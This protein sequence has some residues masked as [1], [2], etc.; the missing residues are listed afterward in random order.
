MFRRLR[1]TWRRLTALHEAGHAVAD[2]ANGI[3]FG[4]VA[5]L[6]EDLGMIVLVERLLYDRPGFDPATPGARVDA[7]DFAVIVRPVSSQRRPAAAD[8]RDPM[9]PFHG[10]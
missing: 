5:V 3:E 9:P 7:E 2:V 1:W 8:R 6:G 10:T 4:R